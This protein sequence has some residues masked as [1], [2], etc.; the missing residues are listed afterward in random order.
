MVLHGATMCACRSLT[1][2]GKTSSTAISSGLR[3]TPITALPTGDSPTLNPK[4][5]KIKELVEAANRNHVDF[6]WAIHPGG[7]IRWNEADY[8]SLVNKLDMMYDLGVRAFALFFDD[9]DG[10]GRNPV[11]QVDL[12]NRLNQEFVKRKAM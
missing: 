10:E 12:F 7:D 11:K 8:D 3:T 4:L 5:K 1:T 6:I 9:I 2:M